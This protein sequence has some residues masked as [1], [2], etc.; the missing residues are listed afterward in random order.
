MGLGVA[1]GCGCSTGWLQGY[2]GQ[3]HLH[4]ELWG[5]VPAGEGGG[6]LGALLSQEGAGGC[7]GI[8]GSSTNKNRG[9][10]V[11]GYLGQGAMGFR[12][13]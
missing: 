12:S 5:A 3:Q 2:A 9:L 10:C 11:R 1:G 6:G 4:V 7:S 8:L 13:S